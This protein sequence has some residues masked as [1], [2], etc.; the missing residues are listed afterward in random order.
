MKTE[1]NERNAGLM[2]LNK[3]L[4]LVGIHPVTG[5][6]F[7]RRGWIQTVNIAGRQYVTPEAIAEFTRRA[8]AGEFAQEHKAPGRRHE[9]V[10]A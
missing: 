2:A 10:A 6:R 1:S 4:D 8:E 7:R 5:W 3:W 9:E